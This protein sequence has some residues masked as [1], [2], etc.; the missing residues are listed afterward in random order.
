VEPL[1]SRELLSH[2]PTMFEPQALFAKVKHADIDIAP[3]KPADSNLTH[4]SLI[5][6]PLGVDGPHH[7]SRH[8]FQPHRRSHF[9]QSSPA[10]VS[11]PYTPAQVRQAYGINQLSQTGAGQTIAIVDAYDDPTIASDLH[12][13]DRTFGLPDPTFTKVSPS[14]TTP[15]YDSGW[16]MEISLDVEWAHAIAPGA[17]ILLVEASD[18]SYSSL[19]TAVDYATTH[20]ANQVSMSWGGSEFVSEATLDTHFN[21]PGITYTASSGDS[22]AAVT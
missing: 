10:L 9:G 8:G 20:G 2:S 1:E 3:P 15:S 18:A 22:G 4:A 19:L 12:N 6:K 13:F 5:A 21:H 14:G 17:K 16:A 11:A 7:H